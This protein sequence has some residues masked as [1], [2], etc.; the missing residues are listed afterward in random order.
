MSN[1]RY[2]PEFK[3]EAVREVTERGYSVAEVAE[4]PVVSTH[5]LHK[6]VKAVEPGKAD[7]QAAELNHAKKGNP[8]VT[9]PASWYRRGAQYIKISRCGF[10]Q[11]LQHTGLVYLPVC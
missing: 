2:S 4:R 9:R 11:S 3:D 10:N 7:Q 8:Q 6:W 1:Q 5:S